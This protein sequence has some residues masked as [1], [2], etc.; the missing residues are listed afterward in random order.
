M[1]GLKLFALL[2]VASVPFWLSSPRPEHAV[3]E[4]IAQVLNDGTLI[5]SIDS[6]SIKLDS[7]ESLVKTLEYAP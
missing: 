3:E 1:T 4:P 7:L 5:R 6:L 2:F